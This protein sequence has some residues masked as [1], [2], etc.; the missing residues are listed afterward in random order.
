M[1]RYNCVGGYAKVV[2]ENEI[3]NGRIVKLTDGSAFMSFRKAFVERYEY[4]AVSIEFQFNRMGFVRQHIAVDYSTEVLGFNM[5]MPT[6]VIENVTQLEVKLV[7]E[8]IVKGDVELKWFNPNLNEFQREAVVNIMKG[9]AR[10]TPY[11]I[12]G[13]PGKPNELY[14]NFAFIPTTAMVYNNNFHCKR[15]R[16]NLYAHRDHSANVHQCRRQSN[17]GCYSVE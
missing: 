14:C 7:D 17:F 10:P 3:Y 11:V 15:Y 6:Q 1:C 9:K 12:F 4:S 5:L 2:Y 8:K 16:K 13:P